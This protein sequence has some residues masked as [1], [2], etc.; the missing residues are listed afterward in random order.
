MAFPAL[1]WSQKLPRRAE[2]LRRGQSSLEDRQES[3]TPAREELQAP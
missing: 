1:P 2:K 3:L